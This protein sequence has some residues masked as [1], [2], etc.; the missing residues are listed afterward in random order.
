LVFLEVECPIR[1]YSDRLVVFAGEVP[2]QEAL[3]MVEE[4]SNPN[5]RYIVISA[6]THAGGSHKAYREYLDPAFHDDFDAWRGLYK[7]PFKDLGDRR[8]YRNWDNEMR[9]SQQDEDGVVGEII[10]P[11]TVPPFFPSYVNAAPPP[12]ESNYIHRHAGVQAHNRW[13]A[14]FCAEFPSRRAG[15]GQIFVNDIDDAIADVRWIKENGL[16]GGVLLPPIPPD[17][18]WLTAYN[19][20]TYDRLWEVCQDLEIPLNSHSGPGSPQYPPVASSAVI[21][22]LEF[23]V[24]AHRQLLFMIL[25]GVF[26][27][28]PGLKFVMTEQGATWIPSMLR[29]MD[30]VIAKI[31]S[32]GALG[33]LRFGPEHVLPRSA[34]EYFQQN[35]MIGVSQPSRA[36]VA[37]IDELGTD[38]FMWGSD[39]P[40]DEGTYPFTREHFR[41]VFHDRP[42]SVVRKLVGGNAAALYGFDLKA[43]TP[44]A[45]RIGPTVSEVARP[46]Q[47]L[48]ADAN[49]ALLKNAMSSTA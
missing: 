41:Q 45:N 39:Y 18:T 5:D 36:D 13:L 2:K 17:A 32:S 9:N 22:V 33:E 37:T 40:H 6:D 10:F 27:R 25:G 21:Q 49:E 29:H 1:Q 15:I 3:L 31:R 47:E 35:V 34:T 38:F 30:E 48:P 20:P 12:D 23:D 4:I 46:L 28:F 42:P 14:D 11:N 7:N 19:D 44:L 26:E 24:F 8:R 16:R 43:L